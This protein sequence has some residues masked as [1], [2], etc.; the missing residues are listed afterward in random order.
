MSGIGTWEARQQ[1]ALATVP[2]SVRSHLLGALRRGEIA[3]KHII[4]FQADTRRLSVE[5]A[6][7]VSLVMFGTDQDVAAV[8]RLDIDG[9]L[10]P[11]RPWHQSEFTAALA[12]EIT[13]ASTEDED[14]AERVRDA[15]H[16]ARDTRL[17]IGDEGVANLIAQFGTVTG[18][19]V[20]TRI[21][22]MAR[23]ARKGGDPRTLA[24]L[25]SDI[26]AI[27]LL[28]G[29]LTLPGQPTPHNTCQDDSGECA[30]SCASATRAQESL[31]DEV[32]T[33]EDA[34]ALRAIINATPAGKVE[35]LIPWDSLIGAVCPHCT[36]P[37]AHPPTTSQH[38]THETHETHPEENP[39]PKPGEDSVPGPGKGSAP[40]PG[41]EPGEDSVPGPGNGSA[42][43][44]QK[45][46]VSGLGEGSASAAQEDSAATASTSPGVGTDLEV[47]HSRCAPGAPCRPGDGTIP[48]AS[49]PTGVAELVGW[50][51]G[52]ITPRQARQIVLTPGTVLSRILYD[53]ADGRC[54]ERSTSSRTPDADMKRQI[55][56]ADRYGRG[57]GS[58]RPADRCEIDHEK[59]WSTH[60]WTAEINLNSKE[61]LDHA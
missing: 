28:H 2:G 51:S 35:L 31:L 56:A 10:E 17:Q 21:D 18:I 38:E 59:E 5:Q 39:A 4:T 22:D 6:A 23:R 3:R 36:T 26:T 20:I 11:G 7:R 55:W 34:Q 52:F 24:Q 42:S 33:P 53:P 30:C 32:I 54:I 15:A 41:N 14:E 58:R 60:A 44:A 27:L 29:T 43:A 8:E 25:R 45:G 37:V 57:P 47:P 61:A 48:P 49:R 19:A 1:V 13:R 46:S 40:G 12:R 50:N 9:R 16:A